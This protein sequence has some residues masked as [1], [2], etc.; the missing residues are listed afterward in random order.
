[1][2]NAALAAEDDRPFHPRSLVFNAYSRH[3]PYYIYYRLDQQK[4]K[5]LDQFSLFPMLP[6]IS[7]ERSF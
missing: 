3:N 1:Q 5:Q 4:Q 7:Y 6:A 2:G